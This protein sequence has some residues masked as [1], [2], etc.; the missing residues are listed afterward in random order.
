MDEMSF[1]E[2]NQQLVALE[3]QFRSEME[4]LRGAYERKKGTLTVL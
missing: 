2:V 1:D 3:M 4:E